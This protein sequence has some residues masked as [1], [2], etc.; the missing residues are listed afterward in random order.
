MLRFDPEIPAHEHGVLRLF[1]IDTS[2]SAGRLLKDTLDTG[3]PAAD[4]ALAD[5]LGVDRVE[6]EWTSLVSRHDIA[7]MGMKAYL[8]EGHGVPVDQIVEAEE[9]L[10]AAG[11]TILVV[12]SRSFDG[13]AQHLEPQES[14]QPIAVFDTAQAPQTATPM[15]PAQSAPSV[16]ETDV[17]APVPERPGGPLKPWMILGLVVLAG[18]LI[19]VFGWL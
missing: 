11:E 8:A 6:A 17:A 9:A 4:R 5:A 14:L 16:L 2:R 1:T 15:T 12:P 13:A 19:L 3:G 7:A 10:D 18:L